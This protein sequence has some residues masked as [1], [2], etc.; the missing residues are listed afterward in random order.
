[1]SGRA[2]AFGSGGNRTRQQWF[3]PNLGPWGGRQSDTYYSTNPQGQSVYRHTGSK[4]QGH[5]LDA[6]T[7][8][9]PTN[10]GLRFPGSARGLAA[11]G[12]LG[13]LAFKN[14]GDPKQQFP[15]YFKSVDIINWNFGSIPI[16]GG[17]IDFRIS[18]FC[19]MQATLS[20]LKETYKPTVGSKH[21]FGR[22]E[23]V[24]TYKYTERKISMKFTA[25]ADSFPSLQ[26][27]KERV[28]FLA[29]SMYPTYEGGAIGGLLDWLVNTFSASQAMRRSRDR[30]KEPPI[31]MV[32]VGD[33]FYDLPC[34]CTNLSYDW[35][36][37]GRWELEEGLRAPQAVEISMDLV[38]LHKIMPN[39][40]L[41]A[42]FYPHWGADFLYAHQGEDGSQS[43]AEAMQGIQLLTET[44]ETGSVMQKL[45]RLVEQTGLFGS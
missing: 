36:T 3:W 5:I 40:T 34:I 9:L 1:M 38:V 18:E 22:A 13:D 41:G 32:T 43:R 35:L 39:R 20:D 44:L 21:Y 15:F 11:D 37:T 45:N 10:G 29:K 27:L 6:A 26:H 28:N 2:G 12:L 17:D 14:S 16:L 31:M 30:Y 19:A 4:V 24:K 42:Q 23:Q 8:N 7:T 25:Y 33:L